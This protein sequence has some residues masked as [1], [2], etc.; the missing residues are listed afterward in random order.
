LAFGEAES[1]ILVAGEAFLQLAAVRAAIIV[2]EIAIIA[3]LRANDE[4]IT[5][6]RFTD[7][8][9]ALNPVAIP[10]RLN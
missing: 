6:D 10:A 4:F 2:I 1:S 5:A 9:L 7:S 8:A 3:E